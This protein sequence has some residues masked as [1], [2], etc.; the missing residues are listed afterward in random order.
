MQ[1]V[2]MYTTAV[3]PYCVRAKQLLKAKGV[4]QIE[5]IRIDLDPAHLEAAHRLSHGPL[6]HLAC[7]LHLVGGLEHAADPLVGVNEV[8]LGAPAAAVG[9]VKKGKQAYKGAKALVDTPKKRR[10]GLAAMSR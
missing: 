10:G 9:A 1:N 3:C 4:E 2:K 6:T 7:C 8:M 5:E